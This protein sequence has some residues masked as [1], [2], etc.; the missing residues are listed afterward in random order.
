[1][2]WMCHLRCY[3]SLFAQK[4]PYC[5]WILYVNVHIA[6]C[7]H[8]RVIIWLQLSFSNLSLSAELNLFRMQSYMS[9]LTLE[10]ILHSL[11][12]LPD[13]RLQRLLVWPVFLTILDRPP[14]PEDN[15]FRHCLFSASLIPIS[16]T[17]RYCV[18]P[19]GTWWQ[20]A[21]FSKTCHS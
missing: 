20:T 14:C 7:F 4:C 15:Y 8:S 9:K 16:K 19:E 2:L 18:P 3:F 5:K 12:D 21:N 13:G 6:G 1:M 17:L 11:N 10:V